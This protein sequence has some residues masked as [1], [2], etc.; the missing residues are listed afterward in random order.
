MPEKNI[1]RSRWTFKLGNR[2]ST[3][4]PKKGKGAAKKIVKR[5]TGAILA[6]N[7][8]KDTH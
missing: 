8:I 7:S 3:K 1:E 2:G 4:P 6:L 5:A